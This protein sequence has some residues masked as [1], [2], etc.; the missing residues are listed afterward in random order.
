MT[1]QRYLENRRWWEIG[2]VLSFALVGFLA[3]VGLEVIERGR[4]QLFSL[5][6]P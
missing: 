2:M 1:L 6:L 3:N 5:P 4:G